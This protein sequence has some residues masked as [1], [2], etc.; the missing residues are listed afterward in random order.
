MHLIISARHFELGDGLREIV[1]HRLERLGRFDPRISRAEI[2][3]RKEG[4]RHAVEAHVTVER[5][6]PIHAVA[7]AE[8][9]RTA[10]DQV[11]DKLGRQ[12]RRKRG[13]RVDHQ[14]P[15]RNV[16]PPVEPPE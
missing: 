16:P 11:V 3:L 12:L 4:Q 1:E 14:G 8:E 5:S 7:E 10:V 9:F 15:P 2:T 6:G 13:R